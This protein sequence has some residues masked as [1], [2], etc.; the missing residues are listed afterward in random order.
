M[1]DSP[2]V[3]D[4][5]PS[6]FLAWTVVGMGC[7]T[8]ILILVL[9]LLIWIQLPLFILV[10]L[11]FFQVYQRDVAVASPFRVTQVIWEDKNQ[12][13][14]VTQS[15]QEIKAS[16][17]R[18]SVLWAKLLVLSFRPYENTRKRSLVIFSDSA[19]CEPL[20]RLRVHLKTQLTQIFEVE[21]LHEKSKVRLIK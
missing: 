18:D 11:C 3:I 20:R 15:G 14:L 5:H 7:A 6:R 12:W 9:P 13:R 17:E 4:L 10:F 8:L 2:L 19:N 1:L 16:L 21:V